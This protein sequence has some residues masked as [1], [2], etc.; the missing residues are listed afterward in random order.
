MK[1]MEGLTLRE[2]SDILGIQPKA[3]QKR[4]MRA[5]VKPKGYAGPTAVYD[6]SALEAI[7]NVSSRGRPPKAKPENP[8]KPAKK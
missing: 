1:S 5:N 6:K 4:L 8:A 3:A 2:I 7:R